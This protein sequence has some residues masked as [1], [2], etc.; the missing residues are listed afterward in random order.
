[1]E[2]EYVYVNKIYTKWQ[3]TIQCRNKTDK[4]LDHI[5]NEFPLTFKSLEMM[6]F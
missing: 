3:S 6:I 5:Y 1:M 4:K 2:E